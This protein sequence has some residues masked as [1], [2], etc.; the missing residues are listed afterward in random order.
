MSIVTNFSRR[1][2]LGAGLF[3]A[4]ADVILAAQ[5]IG[6]PVSGR[7]LPLSLKKR[8]DVNRLAQRGVTQSLE[9]LRSTLY[10]TTKLYA[11][12]TQ[13]LFFYHNTARI[14]VDSGFKPVL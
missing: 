13:N 1:R 11:V 6:V 2:V 10:I 7:L 3:S 14:A 12:S 5:K 9:I 8:Q 4:D